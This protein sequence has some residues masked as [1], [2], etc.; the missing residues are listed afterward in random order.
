MTAADPLPGTTNFCLGPDP[1][2][3]TEGV[4]AFG[5]ARYRE[6]WPGTDLVLRMDTGG[7]AYELI[8]RPGHVAPTDPFGFEGG[9]SLHE[10]GSGRLVVETPLG[11]IAHE[12]NGNSGRI[13]LT[14]DSERGLNDPSTLLWNS[15]FGGSDDDTILNLVTRPAQGWV[16]VVGYSLS[17]DLPTTTGAH[18]RTAN[19]GFDAFV[20]AFTQDG[21]NLVFC[22]YLGGSQDDGA[23]TICNSG[24]FMFV[25]GFTR[26][27]NFP[28]TAAG[29][30]RTHNGNS[31]G[32]VAEVNLQGG[33]TYSTF[34]GGSGGD[35]VQGLAISPES[36][37]LL[38]MTTTSPD[39][40]VVNWFDKILDGNSDAAVVAIDAERDELSF[41]TYLGG[42]G[43]DWC[44][45][46]GLFE[47]RLYICGL[48]GGGF[49]VTH[50]AWDTTQNL[51]D[52][53]VAQFLADTGELVAATY[54]GGT[55]TLVSDPTE[56]AIGVDV[57]SAG[58]IAVT[59]FTTATNFPTSAN[60]YDTTHN[61]GT[62]V[63]ITRLA[64]D[65]SEMLTSTFLG[66]PGDDYPAD[67]ALAADD[68]VFCAVYTTSSGFPVTPD[69]FDTTF[70]GVVDG[71]LAVLDPLLSTLAWSSYLGGTENDYPYALALI[72]HDAV[73]V[74]DTFS[75][76]FPVT[77]GVYQTTHA[78]GYDSFL[79]RLSP[80]LHAAGVEDVAPPFDAAPFLS[81]IAQPNPF[82]PRVA[83]NFE[84]SGERAVALTIHDVAG[85]RVRQLALA[86]FSDGPH[87]V[88]W[89]GCDDDGR[90][91]PAGVYICRAVSGTQVAWRRL[92]LVK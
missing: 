75:A 59:G 52:G 58:D 66:G 23:A 40:P 80:N 4:R 11:E 61:G 88:T 67:L 1:A 55:E 42:N 43:S 82:N 74:G 60:A 39:F 44:T 69:G 15:Y 45:G 78:G 22:T 26:S 21:S 9:T 27:P 57:D 65:L 2:A 6:L 19:G 86:T 34:I 5:E 81:L 51:F 71:A 14:R 17:S 25:G 7:I 68:R 84:L 31:D 50:G 48:T 16:V 87:A 3:W 89:D 36:K 62:D 92:T 70:N 49:P 18:D 8:A 33:L 63:Y 85:R 30:D 20:A 46:I 72:G 73:I 13:S 12:R 91:V 24:P 41:A 32:F 90:P 76:D 77:S 38:G 79:A 56:W 28:T 10:L 64:P 37:I 35:S 47:D 83:I 29:L 54:I 53:Y